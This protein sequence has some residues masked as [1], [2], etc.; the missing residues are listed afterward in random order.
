M[1][2]LQTFHE[3]WGHEDDKPAPI[4]AENLQAVETRLGIAL[5]QD[6]RTQIL[7]FGIPNTTSKLWEWLDNNKGIGETWSLARPRPHLMEFYTPEKM[8]N[9]L[10]LRL[11]RMPASLLPF[12]RDSQ[13]NQICFDLGDLTPPSSRNAG[14]YVWDHA[15][16]HTWKLSRSFDA[17]VRLYL[18]KKNTF[19]PAKALALPVA[20]RAMLI[21][22][23][24]Q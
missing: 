19:R 16:N 11:V 18:P 14:V 12:A 3:I 20:D 1:G 15:T 21:P 7:G 4:T 24:S 13:G 9:T 10:N 6:Y 5:P 22:K 17:F 2:S 8:L 23:S